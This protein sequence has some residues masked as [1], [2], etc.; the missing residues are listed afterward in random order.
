MMMM[1]MTG[2]Y[3]VLSQ[4]AK[5]DIY[6]IVLTHLNNSPLIFKFTRESYL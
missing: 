5:S 3:F 1:V 4:H 2:V 6:I